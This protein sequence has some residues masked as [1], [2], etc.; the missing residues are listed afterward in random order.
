MT[1]GHMARCTFWDSFQSAARKFHE[2]GHAPEINISGT[3]RQI[4]AVATHYISWERLAALRSYSIPTSVICGQKDNLVGYWNGKLLA[5]ELN[6]EL[7]IFEDAGHGVNEQKHEVNQIIKNL[8]LRSSNETNDMLRVSCSPSR[9]P[10]LSLTFA[11]AAE[12]LIFALIK[13]FDNLSSDN[14]WDFIF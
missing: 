10:I 3:I 5:Q 4:L 8:I 14:T 7:H 1:H 13:L 11:V 12:C 9:H 2:S 6:A